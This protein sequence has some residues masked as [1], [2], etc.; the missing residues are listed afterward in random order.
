MPVCDL[1]ICPLFSSLL[2]VSQV[3]RMLEYVKPS[4]ACVPSVGRSF[5]VMLWIQVC[6]HPACVSSSLWQFRAPCSSA[7]QAVFFNQ[8]ST[9]PLPPLVPRGLQVERVFR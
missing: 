6:S 7:L 4:V 9:Q 8:A 3:C 5:C 1:R 2:L